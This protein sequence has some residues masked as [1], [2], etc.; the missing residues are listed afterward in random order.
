MVPARQTPLPGP[1]DA[2]G[3]AW[4]STVVQADKVKSLDAQQCVIP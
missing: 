4:V 3:Y 2:Y 1:A